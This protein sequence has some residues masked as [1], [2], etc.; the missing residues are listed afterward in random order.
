MVQFARL[1]ASCPGSLCSFGLTSLRS[2]ALRYPAVHVRCVDE[3][4]RLVVQ[5]GGLDEVQVELRTVLEQRGVARSA[6]DLRLGGGRGCCAMRAR[7][8][9]RAR[10]SRC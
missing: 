2:D 10:R 9:P 1:R 3:L 7:S 4:D 5:H 6:G 8:A